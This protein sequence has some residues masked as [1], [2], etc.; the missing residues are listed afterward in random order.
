[1]GGTLSRVIYE[2]EMESISTAWSRLPSSSGSIGADSASET[3]KAALE[4]R[5]T[6]LLQFFAFRQ[7]TPS[8]VVSHTMKIAFLAASTAQGITLLSTAGVKPST[9]VRRYD[10]DLYAFLKTIPF[11]RPSVSSR[12][13]TLLAS[14]SSIGPIRAVDMKDILAELSARA[15]DEQEMVK[16]L[17]WR[18]ALPDAIVR[19][20]PRAM[21]ADFLA[22]ATVFLPAASS[23]GTTKNER[24]VSL[25]MIQTYFVTG[26]GVIKDAP[27]PP[28]TLPISLGDALPLPKLANAFGWKPL[29]PAA[30]LQ[31]LA[32]D[33]L[34]SIPDE[35]KLAMSPPFAQK[36]IETVAEDVWEL[37]LSAEEK[38]GVKSVLENVNCVPTNLGQTVPRAA[39]FSNVNIFPDLPI[40]SLVKAE[41]K[42]PVQRM[43]SE[44]TRIWMRSSE[45]CAKSVW[46]ALAQRSW[47]PRP[48]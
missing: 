37:R 1:M 21:T 2:T 40:V 5:F 3:A 13:E 32:I 46:F 17:Q 31:F 41:K 38:E 27:L 25:A 45:S 14:S 7:S 26:M 34:D 36:V 28:H 10:E 15:L 47:S 23:G 20:A 33:G 8:P 44:R 6:H 16:C 9:E 18:V 43:V 12:A 39:Y 29:A 30:W 48:C 35:F 42:G 22:A 4:D 19:Q 24:V 11:L